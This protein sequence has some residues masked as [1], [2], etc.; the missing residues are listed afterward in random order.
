M[1]DLQHGGGLLKLSESCGVDILR[2]CLFVL[3]VWQVRMDLLTAEFALGNV[4][5]V[6]V[7]ALRLTFR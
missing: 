4:A 7:S 5:C 1:K 2:T 6:S 3:L